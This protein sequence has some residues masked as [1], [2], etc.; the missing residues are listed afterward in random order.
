MKESYNIFFPTILTKQ[1]LSER[2]IYTDLINY[3]I[4]NKH[5]IFV[6]CTDDNIKQIFKK[7]ENDYYTIFFVP[8]KGYQKSSSFRKLITLF[9]IN[10]LLIRLLKNQFDIN[11]IDLII[12]FTPPIT[13]FYLLKKIKFVKNVKIY[14]LLKDIFPQN[15]IDLKIVSKLNPLY[16][17]FRR[18]EK[19]LYSISDM[20]GCMSEKNKNYIL[21]KNSFL[22]KNKVEVNPNTIFPKSFKKTS[23][24]KY[25][26][27]NKYNLPFDKFILLYAG[28][29]GKPQ[30]INY[31]IQSIEY[32]LHLKNIY[33]VII[34]SGTELNKI[35]RWKDLNN[36][37]NVLIKSR[38]PKSEFDEFLPACDIGL[39]F[40]NPNFTIPN[41]P[42][43]LLSYME[44]Y[45]PV[46][47][48]V[49]YYTDVGIFL[50][51]KKIGFYN[52]TKDYKSYQSNILKFTNNPKLIETMGNRARQVLENE[53]HISITYN[54]IINILN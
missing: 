40:L 18:I 38:L 12:C 44:Y 43:R 47:A 50:E 23:T 24:I 11:R 37:E 52:Y 16:Y 25:E 21:E 36:P 4:L 33:Y 3:F 5:Q 42:S 32:T 9:N 8:S 45:M 48:S 26:L 54:K 41:F 14:L 34:G 10:T 28:N 29:L 17:F 49:D 13:F 2:N 15:A 7:K 27:R 39:I 35:L 31:L 1:D 53:F 19:K 46:I 51:K 20:I 30:G 6:T 22:D